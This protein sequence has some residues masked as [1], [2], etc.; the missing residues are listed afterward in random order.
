MTHKTIYT[1]GHS[2]TSAR[3]FINILKHHNIETVI[4][5]RSA[6]YSKYAS[7]FNKDNIKSELEGVGIAYSFMGNVLGGRP[8]QIYDDKFHTADIITDVKYKKIMEQEWY[9]GGI[10][11]LL[12][13]ADKNNV[14]IMCS[15]ENP[16][17][18]HRHLLIT[19]SLLVEGVNVVHIRG[20]AVSEIAKKYIPQS[21]LF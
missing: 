18:C 5:V 4:D 12:K 17:N 3:E 13:I 9:R 15:E 10:S 16:D 14:A 2:N 20:N 8:K 19:Q 6:P 21:T 11:K 7:W 1:I